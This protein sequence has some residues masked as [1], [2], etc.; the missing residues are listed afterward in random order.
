MNISGV[1]GDPALRDRLTLLA[2]DAGWR[3][4][5][6]PDSAALERH[7]AGPDGT[8]DLLLCDNAALPA[9]RNAAEPWV[10]LARPIAD[11][12]WPVIDP[13][14]PDEALLQAL[15]TTVNARRLRERF[16]EMERTEPITRLPRHEEL[17]RSLNRQSGQPLGLLVVQVDHESHLYDQLDP[18]SKTDLLAALGTHVQRASPPTGQ[19]GF[20]DAGCF[21]VALADIDEADLARVAAELVARARQPLAYRGGE[22]HITVSAG[23]AFEAL[24]SDPDRLW[25]QAFRAMRRALETGG[26]RAVGAHT[27]MASKRLPQALEREEFSLVLQPQVSVDGKR[28]SGA[29]A[30]LRWQGMEVGA[31]APSQFVPLAEQRGH[32]ARIGDWVLDRACHEASGWLE[33]LLEPLVLGVNVSPQQFHK[34]AIVDRIQQYRTESWFDPAMLELEL[35]QEAL[36]TLVDD[37]RTQLYRLRDWGVRFALDNLGSGLI[38]AAK[39]LRCP[40]DT[41]KIDRTLIGRME[42]DRDARELVAHIC[43]LA[44][45]FELRVVAVGVETAGQLATLEA[46]GCTDV[47]GYLISPPVSL[48][49]FRTLLDRELNPVS[50]DQNG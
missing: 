19:L 30:L 26:D 34:A 29:E 13:E 35:P 14:Q 45:R 39:L 4:S 9:S 32:M 38:D 21:V 50:G 22:L 48:A 23:Y 5:L 33:H 3:A 46:L 42:T 24:Y 18:V 43:Q 16:A 25:S 7:L 49:Q 20:F 11:R 15:K 37:Y 28:L 8:P 27:P 12:P 40:A 17:F 1:I 31:L 47:Q 2:A 44:G 6:W 41:L 36:L 10:L